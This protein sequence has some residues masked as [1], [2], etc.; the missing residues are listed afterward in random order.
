LPD[1]D[2]ARLAASA[3]ETLAANRQ[4]GVS[5]WDGRAYDYVCP[6]RSVYPFQWLWDSGFHAICL[7]HVDPELAKTEI[8]CLL[9]GLQPDGFLPHMLL[10]DLENHRE[11]LKRCSV[12]LASSHFTATTQ[13]PVLA[14]AVERVYA[15]TKDT[16]YLQE[17][18]PAVNHFFDWLAAH[19]DPDDDGLLAIIQPDESGMDASPVFDLPMGFSGRPSMLATELKTGMQRL[20]DSYGDS[21]DPAKLLR[22]DGFQVEEVLFN[23]IY[24]DGL[25]CLARLSREL[26]HTAQ[27][28]KLDARANRVSGALMTKCW[29]DDAGVFWDL[30]GPE[31]QPL[32]VLTS[33]TL[34]PLILDDLDDSVAHHL[35]QDHLLD[36]AEFWTRYPIPSVAMDEPAFDPAFRTGV[37]W[38]GPTWVN[39]NWYLY[40]G[41][42]AH[43]YENVASELAN[44]TFD[45]VLR[46]GQCEFFNPLTGEGMGAADFSWTSLVLDLLW[47]EGKR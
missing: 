25:R 31:E 28:Q 44:R 40:W 20:F 1:V 43:G 19:R 13:P 14:R 47:A 34:L 35:V 22:N 2:L 10:W 36:P 33:A 32:R 39:I 37:V 29:D 26:G 27:A 17:V 11:Q 46:G 16:A 9:Q 8:R 7:L 45:L 6:S 21:T 42:R 18:F 5:D 41:L 23:T 3:A 24:G 4:Q 30:W 12:V 38:R 15:A